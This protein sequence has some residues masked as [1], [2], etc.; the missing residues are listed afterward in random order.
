[1]KV[2]KNILNWIEANRKFAIIILIIVNLLVVS[3]NYNRKDTATLIGPRSTPGY[4]P[5]MKEYVL[6]TLYFRG[7]N[8]GKE[9][10][11]PYTY[12]VLTPLIAAQLK[13]LKAEDALNLVNIILS[14]LI[15]FYLFKLQLKF[16]LPFSFALLGSYLYALSFPN[17]YYTTVC[18][19][20]P[21][22]IFF[23]AIGLYF[24]ITDKNYFLILLYLLGG[25]V[26]ESLIILPIVH[27][28]YLYFAR[29]INLKSILFWTANLIVFLVSSL[30]VRKQM[31]FGSFYLWAPGWK[32]INENIYRKNTYLSFILTYLHFGIINYLNL[33]Y[34]KQFSSIEKSLYV[35]VFL[36]ICLY[37]YS[38]IGAY[39]DGRFIWTAYPFAIPLVMLYFYRKLDTKA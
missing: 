14:Y 18:R 2:I 5:D 3:I 36:S 27:L 24:I 1:M 22:L 21:M 38:I 19:I 30:F 39:T 33:K 10:D 34:L 11:N 31:N 23:I 4:N 26:K 8:D 7:E 15:L 32:T 12:R 28:S 29:K 37:L 35:G 9:L 17:L 13:F 25:A 20:D 6:M 16:N